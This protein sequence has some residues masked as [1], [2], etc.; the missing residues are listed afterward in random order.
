MYKKGSI[1]NLIESSEY[2]DLDHLEY[3]GMAG[4]HIEAYEIAIQVDF[5][6]AYANGVGYVNAAVATEG[7]LAAFGLWVLT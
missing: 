5:L 2:E 6:V 3:M 1:N 7:V 4:A